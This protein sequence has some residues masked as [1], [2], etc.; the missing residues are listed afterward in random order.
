MQRFVQFP[1]SPRAR[2]NRIWNSSHSNYRERLDLG[3]RTKIFCTPMTDGVAEW[4][5]NRQR[6]NESLG[7]DGTHPMHHVSHPRISAFCIV[8]AEQG[9]AR[10]G[11]VEITD[12]DRDCPPIDS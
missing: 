1:S 9:K 12:V 7:F 10:A 5:W 3:F 2:A 4:Q 11:S 8:R 6:A